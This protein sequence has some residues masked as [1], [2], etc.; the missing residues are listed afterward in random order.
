MADSRAQT[1]VIRTPEGIVFSQPLAGMASR[2]LA[3]LIDFACL[4]AAFYL[5]GLLLALLGFI[6]ASLQQALRTVLYFGISIGYAMCLEWFWR[7]Q[8]VGKRILR[9]R[10]VDAEGMRLQASQVVV[11]NILRLVDM[12]PV[13]Y[14]V[15]GLACLLSRQAQRLG[16]IAANTVVIR[17]PK[18]SEPDVLPLLADKYNSLRD[19]PHLEARLRQRVSP[20]E[21][22]LALQA[23]GRRHQLIPEARL[24]LFR[25]IAGH[26][27]S[28]VAFPGDAIKDL[29]DEQYVQNVVDVVYR[30]R[31]GTIATSPENSP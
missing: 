8:T 15:G 4:A 13:F 2:F 28:K 20:R 19:Y 22:T 14:L 3:W 18:I 24:T 23:L 10:V 16:D 12:L 25:E 31:R 21:A 1:L 9:L 7:G 29:A 11:R 17:L 5:V 26:F 6:S 27:R 30:P